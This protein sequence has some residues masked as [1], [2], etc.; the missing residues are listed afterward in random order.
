MYFSHVQ[1]TPNPCAHPPA[2]SPPRWLHSA[3]GEQV[4]VRGEPPPPP[5][6]QGELW[7]R[8]T[9]NTETANMKEELR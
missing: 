3:S 4:P 6:E 1:Q 7:K 9:W 2:V 8:T 5:P